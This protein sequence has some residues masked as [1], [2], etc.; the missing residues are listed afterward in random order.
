MN[1]DLGIWG[2]LSRVFIFLILLAAVAGAV[3]INLPNIRDNERFRRRILSLE[4]QPT[5]G[6][7]ARTE[8]FHRRHA[9]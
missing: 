8:S 1:V 5:G 4:T 7:T 2:K 6:E 3:V 9:E